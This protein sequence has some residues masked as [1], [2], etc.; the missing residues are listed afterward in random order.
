M[1]KTYHYAISGRSP[2]DDEDTINVYEAETDSEAVTMYENDMMDADTRIP[3]EP[4]PDR[5][6]AIDG[7]ESVYGAAVYVN[8]ILRSESPIEI[9]N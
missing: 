4:G 9:R 8:C 5:D 2:E 3:S 1:S 7:L 6:E